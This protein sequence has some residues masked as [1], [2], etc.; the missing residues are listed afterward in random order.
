MKHIPCTTIH[1]Y[2]QAHMKADK[3]SIRWALQTKCVGGGG[4]LNSLN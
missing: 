1:D 2:N 3:I 4:E